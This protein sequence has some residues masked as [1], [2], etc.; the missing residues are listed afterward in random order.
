MSEEAE[1]LRQWSIPSEKTGLDGF[2]KMLDEIIVP[3][4]ENLAGIAIS[5]P[6]MIDSKNGIVVAAGSFPFL[7][8]V[9]LRHILEERYGIPTFIANDS[10]CAAL[11]E[12]WK[13][14]MQNVQNGLVY[15]IGTAI[16]G[17]IIVNGEVVTGPHCL[18]GELSNCLRNLNCPG[19]SKDN[20]AAQKGGTYAMLRDYQNRIGEAQPVDGK[21]FFSR[22]SSG[23]QEALAVFEEFCKFTASF[24]FTLQMVLDC[25]R[26]AIGGGISAQPVVVD[27]IRKELDRLYADLRQGPNAVFPIPEVVCCYFGND[28]N[29]IG[30][31]KYF[32]N[33][34]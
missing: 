12:C 1:F 32:L 21:I 33:S 10:R 14:S 7:R 29:L 3:N 4:R 13:G 8:D 30:V 27:G 9:P 18:A 24:F 6:G 28:A 16:G 26:I 34:R 22:V 11:A 17:G 19:F 31:L 2:L 25:E 23:E 20:I 15:V 5:M